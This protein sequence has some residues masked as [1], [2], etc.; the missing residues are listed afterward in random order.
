MQYVQQWGRATSSLNIS[1]GPSPRKL[2]RNKTWQNKKYL[3]KAAIN[4]QRE[5]ERER[6]RERFALLALLLLSWGGP[7]WRPVS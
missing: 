2:Y 6:E 5:R 1:Y 3:Q 4:R 7:Y